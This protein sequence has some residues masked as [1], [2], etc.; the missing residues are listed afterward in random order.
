MPKTVISTDFSLNSSK[1]AHIVALAEGRGAASEIGIAAFSPESLEFS[2]F[3]VIPP[4]FLQDHNCS[5]LIHQL[6]FA[7]SVKYT[8]TIQ[9]R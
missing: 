6:M 5:L 8:Y 4:K 3:Q 7:P 2:L 1:T 9:H